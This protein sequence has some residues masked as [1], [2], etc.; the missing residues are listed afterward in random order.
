[1]D[2]HPTGTA[3]DRHALVYD[4]QFSSTPL[5]RRVREQVWRISDGVFP[6]GSHLLDI[7]CGSGDDAIHFAA[8]GIDVAAIDRAPAMIA[9][10]REKAAKARVSD[11]ITPHVIDLEHFEPDVQYDGLFSNFA[12][13]NCVEHLDAVRELAEKA[14]RPGSAVVL[15]TFGRL[16][17]PEVLMFLFKGDLKRAFRRLR[18]EGEGVVEGVRFPVWYHSLSDLKSEF[19]PRFSL[20]RIRGLRSAERPLSAWPAMGTFSDHFVS[21]WRYR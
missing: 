17:L 14:L 4:E 20:E 15:V 16:F 3:F 6:P 13:L 21:V 9:R 2:A 5:A 11:R 7:G 8:Q 18:K 10:L 1:M 12:A 19:G